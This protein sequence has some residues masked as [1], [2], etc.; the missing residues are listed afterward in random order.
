MHFQAPPDLSLRYDCVERRVNLPGMTLSLLVVRD[1]N[2]LLDRIDPAEFAR[3]ERLPYWAELWQ[4]APP[5][6]RMLADP[7]VAGG[8]S[9]L[10]LGCGVGLVGIAAARA[11]AR[12]L[13]TDYDDDALQFTRANI[14]TNI[15]SGVTSPEVRR[16]DWREPGPIGMFD[17][18]AGSDILY[19]RRFF[20]PLVALLRQTLAPGGRALFTDPGRSIAED[21]AT[22]ASESGFAVGRTLV[23]SGGDGAPDV[24]LYELRGGVPR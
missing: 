5:L 24:V 10:E 14:R 12:V 13:M 11:G 8:K 9:M 17:I 2:T 22:Q 4:S 1:T 19:E 16:L 6:A 3:D 23:P 7:A 18:V 20:T 21:F 15:P